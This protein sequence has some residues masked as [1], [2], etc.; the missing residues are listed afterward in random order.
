M[1]AREQRGI[2][3]AAMFRLDRKDGAWIVP[4][5]TNQGKKYSVNL[6]R[7]TCSCPDHQEEGHVCKHIHAV[8]ITLKRE[9]GLNG[10]VTETKTL[11]VAEKVTYKQDWP[12]YNAAQV[13]EK[14]H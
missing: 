4:S 12:N 14:D 3:I 5:Q 11:T 9:L 1:E 8:M 7:R 2:V 6:E 10:E 13:N